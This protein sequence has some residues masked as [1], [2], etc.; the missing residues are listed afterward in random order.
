MGSEQ[1]DQLL[2]G[3]AGFIQDRSKRSQAEDLV[4]WHDNT[5]EG[6]VAPKDDMASPLPLNYKSNSS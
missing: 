2:D 6:R 3:Q 5:R 4:I 1:F